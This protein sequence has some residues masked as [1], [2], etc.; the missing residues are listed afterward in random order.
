MFFSAMRDDCGVLVTP[1]L[2]WAMLVS[3]QLQQTKRIIRQKHEA[4]GPSFH[5]PAL[6]P[7]VMQQKSDN[8]PS[9]DKIVTEYLRKQHALCK[10]LVTTCPPF[11]L[12]T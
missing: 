8:A 2:M 3:F 5:M 10:N 12:L 9:L 4:A 1:L 7:Q 11:S 6:K